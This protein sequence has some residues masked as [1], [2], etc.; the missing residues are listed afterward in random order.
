MEMQLKCSSSTYKPGARAE[1]GVL[2]SNSGGRKSPNRGGWA[3][4][5]R[6]EEE[7]EEEV[8]YDQDLAADV[9]PHASQSIPDIGLHP[10]EGLRQIVVG[11]VYFGKL[12]KIKLVWDLVHIIH[13]LLGGN[14]NWDPVQ[15][16]LGHSPSALLPDTFRL[17]RVRL[18]S[19]H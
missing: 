4:A 15:L 17:H 11:L 3:P 13:L 2:A 16:V 8:A 19:G 14:R 9:R 12:S 18:L 7:V 6:E 5:E 1:N 10:L